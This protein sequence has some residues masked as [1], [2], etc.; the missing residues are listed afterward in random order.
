MIIDELMVKNKL[1]DEA[2]KA[3]E[4]AETEKKTKK[5]GRK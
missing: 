4:A 5:F 3:E 1:V 2:P